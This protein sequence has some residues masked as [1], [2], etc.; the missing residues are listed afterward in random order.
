MD[1]HFEAKETLYEKGIQRLKQAEYIVQSRYRTENYRAAAELFERAGDYQDAADLAQKC[2]TLAQESQRDGLEQRYRRAV[3]QQAQIAEKADADRLADT[4][5]ELGDYK[6]APDRQRACRET[7]ERF[8]RRRSRG[9]WCVLALIAAVIALCIYGTYAGIWKYAEGMLYGLA[10]NYVKATETFEELGDFLDSEKKLEAYREKQLRAREAQERKTLDTRKKGDEISYGEFTWKVLDASDEELLLMPKAIEE[11]G[12]FSH[13]PF[14][15]NGSAD[16]EH[17]SLK[18]YLNGTVLSTYF[19]QEEQGR[20]KDGI[21]IPDADL[22]E[23][24]REQL[25]ALGVDFW[26]AVPGE[27]NGTESYFTGGGSLMAYGCPVESDALSVCP[28]L[29]VSLE[30]LAQ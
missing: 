11:D 20:I 28:V 1:N 6:D 14:D 5:G 23:Q 16:W 30:D 21:R 17:S 13:I 8:V 15:E 12:P 29:C 4:F 2:L 27:E 22:L 3:E 26:V 9:R 10:G 18:Q 19:T 25:S 24:Y 7:S